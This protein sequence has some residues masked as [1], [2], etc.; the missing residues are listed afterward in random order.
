[1]KREEIVDILEQ[2]ALQNIVLLKH[3]EAFPNDTQ[4]HHVS[5]TLGSA[6]LVLL[7]VAAS[8]YDQRTYPTAEYA[9]LMSSDH[10]SLT[11]ALLR[12]VPHGVGVVFKLSSAP[13]AVAVDAAFPTRRTTSLLS[14]TARPDF[15]CDRQAQILNNPN[16]ALLELFETQHHARDW[17]L[18]LLRSG[19]AFVC[20]VCEG[21]SP[22]AACFAFENYQH[23]WEI[24][25]VVTSPSQRRRGY[26]SRAVSTALSELAARRLAP[27]YQVQEDNLP[28]IRLA[29][30]L[31]LDLFLTIT[32]FL[33]EGPR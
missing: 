7:N 23:I 29:Q 18:P 15:T 24:G 12:H 22:L 31:G 16:L 28:S 14:F 13:D 21:D 5:S 3:L 9:A 32:H 27:R 8:T 10:P 33:H 19:R 4:V 2:R 30:S 17:L 26:A 1:M 6:T 20:A 11:Q 25:G